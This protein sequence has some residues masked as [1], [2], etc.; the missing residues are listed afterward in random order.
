MFT[1]VRIHDARTRRANDDMA[2]SGLIVHKN[3]VRYRLAQAAELIGHL[4]SERR[5]HLELALRYLDWY[6][7]S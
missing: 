1:K 3:T 2:A 5:A 6:L 7:P 4:L